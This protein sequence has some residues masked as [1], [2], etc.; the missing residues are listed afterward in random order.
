MRLPPFWYCRRTCRSHWRMSKYREIF[1]RLK[2]EISAGKFVRTGRLPSELAL[3]RRFSVARGTVRQAIAALEAEGIVQRQKGVGA[4]L[5]ERPNL[6]SGRLGLLIP[7][8]PMYT[9]FR[10]LAS[11][12]SRLVQGAGHRL[13]V[14]ECGSGKETRISRMAK[15]GMQSLIDANVEG[16]FFRPVVEEPLSSVNLGIVHAFKSRGIPV[17]LVDSDIVQAPERSEFDLVGINNVDAGRRVAQHLLATG[18][19]RICYQLDRPSV[20]SR[21]RFFGVMGAVLAAGGR[22]ADEQIIRFAPEDVASYRRLFARRAS[23]PD[24]IVCEDDEVAVR[25]FKTLMSLG[26]RVPQDVA[27]VG[28]DD[29]PCAAE[30]SPQLTTIH[31]PVDLIADVALRML[32]TR[33]R[34]PG[35]ATRETLLDA[36]LIVREST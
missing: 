21:N 5:S 14:A 33:I 31:Q 19:K 2:A 9:F 32:L 16:V 27:L 3:Q 1:D 17:V 18:R 35:I 7:D 4:R 22:L 15:K 8:M 25:V 29:V 12:L 36:P 24:A 30:H 6:A 10:L 13:M 28:C 23:R 11:E 26:M 34:Q 20:V